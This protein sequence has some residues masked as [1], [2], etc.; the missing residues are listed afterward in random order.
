MQLETGNLVAFWLLSLSLVVVPG[1]DWAYAISAGLRDKAVFPAVLGMLTGYLMI[2]LV[3]AAGIGALVASQPAI[4]TVL[5]L[6]GAAYLLWLGGNV[7]AHPSEPKAGDAQASG[8]WMAWAARGFAVSGVNPK[9][10]LLFLALLPQFTSRD[11]AWPISTQITALGILQILNCAVIYTL[12][13]LGSKAVL[14]TRPAAARRVSQF[15]GLAM[16]VIA[17]VLFGEQLAALMA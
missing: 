13:G 11:G 15:S 6:A 9:A 10:I 2:T 8:H 16:I 3:V 4:L 14:Q 7:L 5:T 1:A 17:L 12:V